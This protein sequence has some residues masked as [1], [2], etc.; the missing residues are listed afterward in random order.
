M[1]DTRKTPE[2]DSLRARRDQRQTA[3]LVAQYMHELSERHGRPASAG[4]PR[5]RA[6]DDTRRRHE[7]GA[8]MTGTV[9]SIGLDRRRPAAEA[10]ATAG[11]PSW[12]S[13]RAS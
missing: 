12:S 5:R 3:G 13:A 2:S 11:S 1:I 10:T 7:P 6:N 9:R 4:Q 8:R